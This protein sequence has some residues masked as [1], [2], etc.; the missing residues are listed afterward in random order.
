MIWKIF[1]FLDQTKQHL[2]SK[3][4]KLEQEARQVG[5]KINL[6]KT[7]ALS[8]NANDQAKITTGREEIEDV[9]EFTLA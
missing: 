9:E 8:I 4:A 3:A 6:G 2:Q 5:L 1:L 7:K